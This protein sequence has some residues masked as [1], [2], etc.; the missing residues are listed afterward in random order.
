MGDFTPSDTGNYTCSQTNT[1]GTIVSYVIQ[2][3]TAGKYSD[4]Y[5]VRD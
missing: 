2:I 1:S 4:M 3:R 5:L